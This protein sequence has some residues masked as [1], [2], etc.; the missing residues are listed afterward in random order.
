MATV[1]SLSVLLT[2]LK[3]FSN[4]VCDSRCNSASAL[5]LSASRRSASVSLVTHI[6]SRLEWASVKYLMYQKQ[7]SKVTTFTPSV[8]IMSMSVLASAGIARPSYGFGNWSLIAC[9]SAF[10]ASIP[11]WKMLSSWSCQDGYASARSR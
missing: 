11:L 7:H 2:L 10:Q 3:T 8:L 6:V 5:W 1:I 9:I 4:W